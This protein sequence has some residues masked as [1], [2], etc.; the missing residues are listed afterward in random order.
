MSGYMLSP[1]ALALVFSSITFSRSIQ[2]IW[3]SRRRRGSAPD[4]VTSSKV[5]SATSKRMR[6]LEPSISRKVH[7]KANRANDAE[8]PSPHSVQQSHSH[9]QS[10]AHSGRQSQDGFYLSDTTDLDAGTPQGGAMSSGMGTL[11][12]WQ[13]LAA[14]VMKEIGDNGTKPDGARSKAAKKSARKSQEDFEADGD[15]GVD[16]GMPKRAK[17]ENPAAK[18]HRAA[19]IQRRPGILSDDG[20]RPKTADEKVSGGAPAV[21]LLE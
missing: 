8:H 10:G 17:S 13:M 14:E 16:V 20:K 21:S 1:V 6:G 7:F 3:P 4:S 9:S 12:G 19:P 18:H 11:T 2:Y 15:E 5:R